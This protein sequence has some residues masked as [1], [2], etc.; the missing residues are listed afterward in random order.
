MKDNIIYK[1]K[2]EQIDNEIK[3]KYKNYSI[4]INIT[5]LSILT[6]SIFNI[7]DDA[8]EFIVDI[9]DDNKVIIKKVIKNKTITI[10]LK[11][12]FLINKKM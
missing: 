5:D 4:K 10:S 3:I 7:I 8:Y 12:I 9:F 2:I 6:K 1:F 11:F